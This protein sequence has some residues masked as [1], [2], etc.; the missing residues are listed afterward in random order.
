MGG[1]QFQT[2]AL[3]PALTVSSSVRLATINDF[4]MLVE[5]DNRATLGADR[6]CLISMLLQHAKID[7]LQDD[8][9]HIS[10][11]AACRHF[12]RGNVIGPSFV[13]MQKPL[14]H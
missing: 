7:V 1:R 5:L 11:Y 12:G 4:D 2:L 6:R 3:I 13:I 9:E 8:K 14:K 10:G